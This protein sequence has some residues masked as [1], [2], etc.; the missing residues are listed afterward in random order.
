M[1]KPCPIEP[2]YPTLVDSLRALAARRP[3]D[4]VYHFLDSGDVD[5]PISR[6]TFGG[7]D[8]R[9]R[10]IAAALTRAGGRGERVLLAFVPGLDFACA[11]LGCLYAGAVAVPIYLPEPSRIERRRPQLQAI[12][13]SARPLVGL[14][15]RAL[16]ALMEPL[17][18]TLPAWN[19]LR[20]LAVDDLAPTLAAS[21]QPPR[22]DPEALA[23]LQYTSGSTALPRGV[24]VR[25]RN[26]V[27]NAHAIAGLFG[28]GEDS[29]GFLWLPPYHDMGLIGGLLVPVYAGIPVYLMSP[30]AFL[31][32]PLR[33]L[34]GISHFRATISGGPNFAYQL[35]ARR[36]RPEDV[37]ALDL[38]SWALAFNG[39]ERVRAETLEQFASLLGPAGFRRS[40]FYPC[41]GLAESTLLVTGPRRGETP[42]VCTVQGDDLATGHVRPTATRDLAAPVPGPPSPPAPPGRTTLTM[43]GCGRP[44]A[45]HELVVVD[46]VTRR[47]LGEEQVGELWVA[48]PS[49]AQ[50]YF[51]RPEETRACFEGTLADTGAGPFLRTGDLGFVHAG[52]VFVTGR[53]KDLIIVRGS[54]LYPEDIERAVEPCHPALRPGGGAAFAVESPDGE[55]LVVVHEIAPRSDRADGREAAVVEAATAAIR[56]VVAEQFGAEPIVVLVAPRTLPKTSSGKIQ[57]HACRSEYLAGTLA[58][59]GR[60]LALGGSAPARGPT[61]DAIVEWLAAWLARRQGTDATGPARVDVEQSLS[62]HGLD[63]LALAE[64]GDELS[65]WTERAVPLAWLWG[66]KSLRELAARLA[67]P[68]A[69]DIPSPDPVAAT[70]PA[71][72]PATGAT[73][74]GGATSSPRAHVP[75]SECRPTLLR[76]SS[77]VP[78]RALDQETLYEQVFRP[79][80]RDLPDAARLFRNSGVSWRRCFYGPDELRGFAALPTG[81]RMALWKDGALT[82]GRRSMGAALAGLDAQ[83]IGSLVMV[84]CTGY[85]TPSPDLLL[86]GEFG[87]RPTLRRT[88]I[89]HMGCFAAFRGIQV[90]LD[91]LAARPDEAVLVTCT[92]LCSIHV[93]TEATVEQAVCHAL[94]GDASAS[95]VLGQAP[96]GAGPQILATRSEI[97]YGEA[98]HMGW[99]VTNTGFRMFLSPEVPAI[100]GREVGG[101]VTRLLAPLR[102]GRSDIRHWGIHPGGPKIVEIVAEALEIGE[103]GRRPALTVLR[104][105]GNCSSPTVLLVLEHILQKEAPRPGE[106]GV[107]L[108]FGPGL[109]ME[110]LVLRF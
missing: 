58:A 9:A 36:A 35:C 66:A 77:A 106:H 62:A 27:H 76:L 84:S 63:S 86:A 94:F 1:P 44:P 73:V 67:S 100:L 8:Q 71:P 56:R 15:T 11:F 65:R 102:L 90:A 101:F 18:Q 105:H 104:E 55:R 60:A 51:G 79:W 91:A 21:W 22:L 46:P 24:M 72:P 68:P 28:I 37:A 107:L 40:A 57:R 64:L 38:S 80:Y 89:G 3:H 45:G 19:Q 26:L 74:T 20:W 16:H 41:Y 42:V 29:R 49:V 85:D 93:R 48:G 88:F 2:R 17:G 53:L 43:V 103:R 87:L 95:L 12:V 75:L 109:T 14:T 30:L 99:T 10:T 4:P 92:E 23:F 82:L 54:N 50:G 61:A 33:W 31:E 96:A 47:R 7:L 81:D 78:D 25:H 39:A 69:P 98:K 59:V 13:E 83:E 52:Q 97:L 70:L 5:G 34:R 32:R 110:G 108:A 6:L